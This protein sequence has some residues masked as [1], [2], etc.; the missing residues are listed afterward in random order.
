MHWGVRKA[1]QRRREQGGRAAI[2]G[3]GR[4]TG[5]GTGTGAGAVPD[6]VGGREPLIGV[7]W[8]KVP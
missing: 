8:L 3:R 2:R 7:Q 6:P 5:T 4:G 1:L